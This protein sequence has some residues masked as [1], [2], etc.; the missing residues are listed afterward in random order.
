MAQAS[1]PV[2]AL[3][4]PGMPSKARTRNG[5]EFDPATDNWDFLTNAGRVYFK[6]DKLRPFCTPELVHSFKKTLVWYVE[7]MSL[8]YAS[9]SFESLRDFLAV[10]SKN[11]TSDLLL[12]EISEA[13]IINYKATLDG[14]REWYLATLRIFFIKMDRLGYPGI[15]SA[16][17][18][19]L[20][21]LT[22][23]GARKGWA[24][25]TMDP[26]EGPFTNMELRLI[27]G[28][29][30]TAYGEG[31]LAN[32]SYS[33]VWLY[34]ALGLR[35]SQVA[36]LKVADLKVQRLGDS[37]SYTL[38]VPRGKQRFQTRRAE[39]KERELIEPVG[40]VL[41][42]WCEQVKASFSEM[43]IDE[44]TLPI[45]PCK[46]VI[47]NAEPG[48]E[49]HSDSVRL[50]VELE[51]IF[52]KLAIVS[53][54]TGKPLK[55]SAYRFRY[56]LGARA[57]TEKAGAAVIAELLDHSDMQN[58]MVYTQL[59]S[60]VI[61]AINAELADELVPLAQAF[62][63]EVIL[64]EDSDMSDPRK[65]IRYPGVEPGKG[66]TGQ[67]RGAGGCG[68]VVPVACYVC[69]YFTAFADGPHEEV[70]AYL[71]AQKQQE[72]GVGGDSTVASATE[73]AIQAIRIVIQKCEDLKGGSDG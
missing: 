6:I 49:H 8:V 25:L 17:S 18:S 39:F 47:D 41:F 22:L 9:I 71:L 23:K 40:Q 42:A 29:V 14:L 11:S 24:V 36:D 31:V 3:D 19:L 48:F 58:V 73:E 61:E 35:P 66:T 43:E 53:P 50:A 28:A 68:A 26:E 34:M 33:L 16:A 5:V 37:T 32:R 64:F 30:N 69:P 44:F 57:V 67:C 62:R 55:A 27:Q 12:S 45:F 72:V 46:R 1:N 15:K 54:R 7:N 4:L 2:P 60:E 52:K 38:N 51:R 63:G 21:E 56:T 70:L 10:V 59:S 65:L 20:E 13:D